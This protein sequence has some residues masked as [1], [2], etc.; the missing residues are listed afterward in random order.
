M[1]EVVSLSIAH[2]A[3]LREKLKGR[4]R[5][6]LKNLLRAT[7]LKGGAANNGLGTAFVVVGW[8]AMLFTKLRGSK[9]EGSF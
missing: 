4:S 1:L 8:M 3:K 6:F 2:V 7:G 5:Q 9:I